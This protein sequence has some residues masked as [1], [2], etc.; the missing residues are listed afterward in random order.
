VLIAAQTKGERKVLILGLQ[1]ENVKRL[2]NDQPIHKDLS[3]E[4]VPGLEEWD[5]YVLGPEDTER[6]VAQFG[7]R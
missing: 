3:E 6:F 7:P 2:L 5:I 1:A 4:A